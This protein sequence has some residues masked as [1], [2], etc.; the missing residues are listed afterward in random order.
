[1]ILELER[2]KQ[3]SGQNLTVDYMKGKRRGLESESYTSVCG[4][5]EIVGVVSFN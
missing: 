3:L 4:I 1:M 5:R 2:T